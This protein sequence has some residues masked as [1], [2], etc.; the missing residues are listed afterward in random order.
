MFS[1]PGRRAPTGFA[2][3]NS[4]RSIAAHDPT[5]RDLGPANVEDL[6]ER[7]YVSAEAEELVAVDTSGFVDAHRAHPTGTWHEI[8]HIG[9]APIDAREVCGVSPSRSG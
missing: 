8:L 2:C 9:D 1:P 7:F 6:V 4:W 5:R 3:A